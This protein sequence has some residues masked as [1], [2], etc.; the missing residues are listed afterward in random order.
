MPVVR[1]WVF[2]TFSINGRT[3]YICLRT[4][5]HYTL[6][7]IHVSSWLARPA[8]IRLTALIGEGSSEVDREP[9]RCRSIGLISYTGVY[10]IY[11]RV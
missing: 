6:N 1:Q 4:V 3:C 9:V 11:L 2:L 7:A 10:G 5:E 8:V